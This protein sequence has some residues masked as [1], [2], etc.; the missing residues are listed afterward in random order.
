[1]EADLLLCRY[2]IIVTIV[3]LLEM[4]RPPL[5]LPYLSTSQNLHVNAHN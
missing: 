4:V 1:M 2:M 3:G 5:I